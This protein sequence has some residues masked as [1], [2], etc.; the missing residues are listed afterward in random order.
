ML[1]DVALLGCFSRGLDDKGRIILPSDFEPEQGDR[2]AL[3]RS[4][5]YPKAFDLYPFNTIT[6]KISRLDE[7]ILTSTDSSVR[8]RAL[9]MRKEICFLT[10]DQLKI[11]ASKRLMLG[12]VFFEYFGIHTD[13]VYLL[14]E[15]DK[16]K[17]LPS[18]DDYQ[19]YTGIPYVKRTGE[20]YE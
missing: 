3:C 4:L 6:S 1:G 17:L 15:C 11:G 18:A 19:E 13:R 14:G 5:D 8:D 2:V 7:L 16:I 10:I 20:K 12:N 9:A